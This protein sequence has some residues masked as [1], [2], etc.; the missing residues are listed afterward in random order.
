[1]AA[2]ERAGD[3]PGEDVIARLNTGVPHIARIYDYVLGG[4]ANF[5]ADRAAARAF[6]KAMP[7]IVHGV[8][9][10]RAFLARAVTFLAIEAGIRQFL[11][12]GTGLPTANNTHEVAQRVAPESR[13]AYVDNDPLV[14]AHAR[15]LLTS[16]PE[17]MTSYIDADV[18]DT[19]KILD[20]AGGVLDFSRPVAI[21]LIGVLHCIPD[22]D[23]PYSIMSR[24]MAAAPSGSYLVIGHPASDIQPESSAKAT[25]GLNAKLAEPVTFRPYA[26]VARFLD[27]LQVLEPGLVHYSRWRPAPGSGFPP[28][29][30]AWCA[31]A[32]KP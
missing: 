24:L 9:E 20:A 1:V 17:G 8:K 25:A 18:R 12:I 28:P 3:H 7:G 30:A 32:R 31:V 13:I 2:D 26:Q 16:S 4:E 19:S 10:A 14:L 5:P 23:D 6:I 15:A 29:V 22:S 27:G 11:D 21:M